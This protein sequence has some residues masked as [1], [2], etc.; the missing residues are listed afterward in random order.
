MSK[1]DEMFKELGY[2]KREDNYLI[3]YIQKTQ[4]MEEKFQ[5]EIAFAKVSKLVGVHQLIS[6]EE[7]KAINEKVRELQWI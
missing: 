2:E 6:M 7:L 5:F 4:A 1:A 3:E